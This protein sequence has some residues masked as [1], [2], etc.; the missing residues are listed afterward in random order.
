MTTKAEKPHVISHEAKLAA[1]TKSTRQIARIKVDDYRLKVVTAV[2]AKLY[3]EKQPNGNPKYRLL[4][5][6]GKPLKGSKYG[7]Q[8]KPSFGSNR[9]QALAFQKAW[10][11]TIDN[12]DKTTQLILS[13]VSSFDVR[14]SVNQLA[15]VDATLREAVSFYLLHA[16]PEGGSI[17]VRDAMD[18]FMK[19]QKTRG[20]SSH[21]SSKDSKHYKT[22]WRPIVDHFDNK[23]LLEVTREDVLQ[24]LNKRDNNWSAVHWNTHVGNGSRFWRVLSKLKYC[25][26]EL[27]PWIT[28]SKRKKPPRR[29]S[30]KV[31]TAGDV[32]SLFWFTEGLA[33]GTQY[34]DKKP[35]VKYWKDIA[36]LALTCFMGVRVTEASKCEWSQIQKNV[37]PSAK[38]ETRHR[39]TIFADQEKTQRGKV[40]PIP[41]CA[42]F[43]LALAE[44]HKTDDK[45]AHHDHAQR[46]K[47]LRRKFEIYRTEQLKKKTGNDDIKFRVPVN[48]ARHQFCAMHLGLYN[49]YPLTVKR[50]NHGN[51]NTMR[52]NYE[53]ICEPEQA[54]LF[55]KTY[56]KNVWIRM[57]QNARTKTDEKWNIIG[58]NG[59]T[60]RKFYHHIESVLLT[61]WVVFA[62]DHNYHSLE[63]EKSYREGHPLP[64]GDMNYQL[65]HESVLEAFLGAKKAIGRVKRTAKYKLPNDFD[66]VAF[67]EIPE[68]PI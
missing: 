33:N 46:M 51:V 17:T 9:E 53:S 67:F 1:A 29:G 60:E 50:L 57:Q 27:D 5:G 64:I 28:I 7:K 23:L 13:D 6:Y 43:W 21:S 25:S 61:A 36:F 52:Q 56:P 20:N 62:S 58:V 65:T 4:I 54:Q 38:D 24:Y 48:W 42:Q 18:L 2:E 44:K 16:L 8:I 14:W 68:V 30:D 55:F 3:R 32:M 35:D 10:N 59:T 19:E 63:A 41:E 66:A 11:D 31:M 49:D 15:K 39:L 45:I 37:I 34:P 22:Y 40:A 47:R 26:T 12:Q